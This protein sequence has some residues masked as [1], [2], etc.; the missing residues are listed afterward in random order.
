MST[1][2]WVCSF[3]ESDATRF[4]GDMIRR[5]SSPGREVGAGDEECDF[6]A[7]GALARQAG[8]QASSPPARAPGLGAETES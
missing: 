1:E 3:K 8:R 5:D 7:P 2:F 4:H 6:C